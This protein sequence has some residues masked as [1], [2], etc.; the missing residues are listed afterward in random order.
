MI[1]VL[2]EECREMLLDVTDRKV[3]VTNG[4]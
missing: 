2:E 3:F 4:P 1:V